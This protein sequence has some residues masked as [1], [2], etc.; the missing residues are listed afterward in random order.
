MPGCL[1]NYKN[2]KD[3][4]CIEGM[5]IS[6]CSHCGLVFTRNFQIPHEVE[7][8]Y[9][10]NY[11]TDK[12]EYQW[13]FKQTASL[14]K[15][16][17]P[18]G[19]HILDVGCNYGGLLQELRRQGYTAEGIDVSPEMVQHAQKAGLAVRCGRITGL[20]WRKREFDIIIYNHVLEHIIDLENELAAVDRI[21]RSDGL[22]VVGVPNFNSI[23]L[24][25]KLLR[26]TAASV[27]AP[28]EHVWH[29]TPKTLQQVMDFY[30]YKCRRIIGQSLKPVWYPAKAM[31]TAALSRMCA[32][33]P[34]CD[35]FVGLFTKKT[36]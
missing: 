33:T 20:S 35:S 25:V 17:E 1:C 3:L 26:G 34:W 18:K 11:A 15:K 2:Y 24:R 22:L 9:F 27:L 12:K 36:I 30:G 21:I 8:P 23:N 31:M 32:H 29:F 28:K 7:R 13:H 14:I 10:V 5:L 6:R 4:L 19:G 16:Y